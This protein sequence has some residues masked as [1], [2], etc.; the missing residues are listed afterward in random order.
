M[1][2]GE[3]FS[4]STIGIGL[5]LFSLG[6]CKSPLQRIELSCRKAALSL[7]NEIVFCFD[8]HYFDISEI[9]QTI[10]RIVSLHFNPHTTVNEQWIQYSLFG[11]FYPLFVVIEIKKRSVFT[12]TNIMPHGD[13]LLHIIAGVKETVEENHNSLVQAEFVAQHEDPENE[14]IGMLNEDIRQQKGNRIVLIPPMHL[15]CLLL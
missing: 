5:T 12:K 11:V 4:L 3:L 8:H 2:L 10:I 7:L 6:E 9:E 13:D 15:H 1:C 14:V